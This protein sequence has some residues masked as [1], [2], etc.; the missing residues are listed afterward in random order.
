MSQ[1]DWFEK[2]YYKALGVSKDA[3][4]ADIKKAY[5]KEARSCHPDRNPGDADAHAKFQALG[6]SY[7]VLSSDQ[8]RAYYDKYGLDKDSK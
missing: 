2:D 6:E 5:Y 1:K 8:L 3:S 4:Q 7:R